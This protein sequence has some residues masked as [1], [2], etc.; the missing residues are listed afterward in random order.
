MN[1]DQLLEK[2][3]PRIKVLA[4]AVRKVI[5]GAVP[6]AAERVKW[7]QPTYEANGKNVACIMIYRDHVN[8][9]FFMGAT[10][11]SKRLEGTGKGLRHVKVRTLDDIDEKELGRLLREAVSLT[12]PS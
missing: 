2:E 7:G 3:E 8:L 10:M 9:G 1:V 6:A 12:K 4:E 11:K 5:R